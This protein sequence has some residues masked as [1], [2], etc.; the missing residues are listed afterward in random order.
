VLTTDIYGKPLSNSFYTAIDSYA[1][2]VKPKII[3]TFLD[4]RHIDNLTVTTNDTHPSNSK[5]TYQEQMSGNTS[6]IGYFF[7]PEQS[8][9]GIERQAYTWAVTDDYD[10]YGNTIKADGNWHCMPSDLED[11]YEFGW[12]G[13][14]AST[15]N[16]YVDGGY[17]LTNTY[18]EYSFTQRKVNKIKINT[19]EFNG[20][21]SCYRIDVYN[22]SLSSFYNTTSTFSIDEYSK[23]HLIP[24]SLSNDVDKIKITIYSTQNP[25]DYPRINEVIP[26]Y[27]VDVTDYV[28]NHSIERSGELWE[29]SIPI[30]GTGSSSASIT[31][32]NTTKLFN[33]F[34]TQT[35]YGKYMKKDLKINIYNGWRVLKTNNVL[36]TNKLAIAMNTSVTT[37]TLH[38]ASDFLNGNST[39]TFTVTIAPN[40][41]N[42]EIVLCSSRT[43]KT[44]TIL[45]RGYAGT[46]AKSHSVNDTV[47]F[48]PYEYV[49]GGEFYV[50]EW[51][52]G[53]GMQVSIKCLDKTKFLTEKQITKGFYVQNSTV[54]DAIKRMLMM[55][56]IPKTQLSQ[57]V[58]YTTFLKENA[59][60]AYSFSIPVQRDED[61]VTPG[62]GLRCRIWK[63]PINK[64]NEVK[65][66]K[67]DALD[68]VLTDYD[69]AMGAKPYIPPTYISYSNTTSNPMNS[70]TNLAVDMQNFSFPNGSLTESEYYNGVIDGYYIPT[71]SGNQDFELIIKNG[72]ARMYIDDTVV[73]DSWNMS[74]TPGISR[75]LSSY[76][77][78]G[79]H[80]DLDSG[81][82][83]KVRIEFYHKNGAKDTSNSLYLALY[84]SVV[85]DI[86]GSQQILINDCSTVVVED[87]VGS[88]NTTFTKT[89]KNRNH[90]KNNGLYSGTV[91]LDK[92]TGLVSEP[93][94]KSI[95]IHT[96]G[97]V[98]IPYDQSLNLAN[99][100][101]SNYTGE[102][103]YECYVKFPN[104]AFTGDGTYL[105]NET[106]VGGTN[107]GFSFFYNNSGHGYTLHTPSGSKTVSS[108]T[109]IDSDK[110]DH[111][112]ITYKDSTLK[113]YHDGVLRDTESNVTLSTFGLGDIEIGS[114]SK[115]FYIDEFALYNKALDSETIK[116]RWY[117]T[118][119]KELTVFPH[120]YGNEQ[121]AKSIL[122]A[123]ALADFG[124]MYIDEKDLFVYNH[125]YRYFEPSIEQ[126]YQ[127][128]KEIS[129]STHIIS[130]EYN[131]QLQANKVTVSVTEQNPIVTA[132]QG[133]WTASPDPSS[134]AV[135][136]L[137]ENINAS[138]NT[139]PVTTTDKPPFP[140]SGYI[141][142][143]DEIMKYSSIDSTHFLGVERG[144]F[145]TTA[146][147]HYAN[148]LVREVRYYDIKYDNS[149][150]FNVQR[151][152][153]TGVSYSKPQQIE[154]V[155]FKTDAYTA[156]MVI[157]ASSS[158]N[159]GQLAY[160][161]GTNP[162]TGE[163]NFTA[164]A[165]VPIKKQDSSNLVKKQS[166]TLS[167]D[168]KKY[169]L[170][171]VV[172]ENEYIYSATKA[173]EIA[174]FIIDKFKNP[175]PVLNISS[176]AIPTLQIG[177][178]I[179]ITSLQTLDIEDLE[180]WV[181]SHS[182]NVGD[183]LDHSITLR[184]V[185]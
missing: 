19:S 180:Y 18:I 120:L 75:T 28:V 50:D 82:P 185:I 175:V 98:T 88:R 25:N 80:L 37:M 42:E 101:S 140:K 30:A 51:S 71:T 33:P 171:E 7:S 47:Q 31:L 174:D 70:N 137:T 68:I 34:N 105:T 118:Q 97:L 53:S 116:N 134:L 126:H 131:V 106:S 130:G 49:N 179:R 138:A 100:N 123:I 181:V 115:A 113:Y 12:R 76:D 74:G 152:F 157:A 77:Y 111:F 145:D 160:I 155:K 184:Q 83:Y 125:F 1:Q 23:E 57:I 119:V 16:S 54:G 52:G 5:G 124:R 122:D 3:I 66:I 150:A 96:D 149:P 162:L 61:T 24:S 167:S 161:Q 6:Q 67:A 169:G 55:S 8:M 90:Y 182:L 65:D 15:S 26:L 29:N 102:F 128:Q 109:G 163:V 38:D 154:L 86:N 93:K 148:D 168:I 84:N 78:M 2:K 95:Y 17:A 121:S 151:P 156:E 36:I 177:D 94:N 139:I 132:K 117:S 59:I 176:M 45:Q 173:Q 46:S 21:I 10:K 158:V 81:I 103:T 41:I 63:T 79:R 108:N 73:I 69:K 39:N 32:D 99:S 60:A 13:N 56:N 166:A 85:G 107:Y 172:I 136:K 159:E 4:S 183:T 27:E 11:N 72:G 153:I 48:D 127:V 170:K 87:I 89:L 110:W 40:T 129:G 144:Y 135:V 64:E 43:D 165:G 133:L 147:S 141:K 91:D 14:T 178:R 143:Q 62:N 92:I 142:I 114:S 35:G 146:D 58:P 44:I 112:C 22:N 9:N 20:K 164:I 104:G